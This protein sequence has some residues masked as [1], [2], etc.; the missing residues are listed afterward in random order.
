MQEH[1]DG[2]CCRDWSRGGSLTRGETELAHSPW[3]PDLEVYKRHCKTCVIS[4]VLLIEVFV[5]T[6][7]ID[8]KRTA[9]CVCREG[10]QLRRGLVV[11]CRPRFEEA[12]SWRLP[13][14]LLRVMF[15]IQGM[16]VFAAVIC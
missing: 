5:V 7:V 6:A 2:V 1:Q 16:V 13:G 12:L 11:A 4:L 10:W 15:D 8:Q 14:F 3:F 9:G